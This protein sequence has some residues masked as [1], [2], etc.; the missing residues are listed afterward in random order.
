MLERA[1]DPQTSYLVLSTSF[2]RP[3]W[4]DP[5][6]E[7]LAARAR[8]LNV[9]RV[10]ALTRDQALYQRALDVEGTD[11]RIALPFASIFSWRTIP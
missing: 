2:I 5:Y 8:D 3:R 9:P 6:F 4:G 7:I 10:V 11:A 1:A